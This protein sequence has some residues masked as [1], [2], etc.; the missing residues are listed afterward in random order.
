V[1]ATTYNLNVNSNNQVII[2]LIDASATPPVISFLNAPQSFTIF[3]QEGVIIPTTITM[4]AGDPQF[5]AQLEMSSLVQ[6]TPSQVVNVTVTPGTGPLFGQSAQ[7][8]LVSVDPGDQVVTNMCVPDYTRPYYRD[9]IRRKMSITPPVD[10]LPGALPGQEP[11]GQA[12]PSNPLVNQA[13]SDAIRTINR[14]CRFFVQTTLTI[15]VT[16]T[17]TNGPQWFALTGLAGSANQ[18]VIQKIL[19]VVWNNGN[20][21][22]Y[23]LKGENWRAF[24]RAYFQFDN[25]FPSAPRW[26]IIE[27]YQLGILPGINVNGTLQIWAGTGI[28][29]FCSD[30]DI[31]NQ[32]P[33]DYQEVIEDLAIVKLN[34]TNPDKQQ[35]KE[36]IAIF[37]ESA[38][39]GLDDIIKW[40]STINGL[41][42]SEITFESRRVYR[43]H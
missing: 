16:A 28:T 18:N 15:P 21:T 9:A 30:T 2:S 39:D 29:N 14:K 36:Q 17:T 4:A 41:S 38:K 13:I 22:V 19:R 32:L 26:Y 6:Y 37:G 11:S 1:T 3:A 43:V 5:A 34:S 7:I 23:T 12:W 42:Q 40:A 10:T 27:G 31:L 35:G 33:I 25:I 8:C 20:G 24:D